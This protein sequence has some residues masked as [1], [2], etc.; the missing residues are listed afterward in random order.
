MG[1]KWGQNHICPL[2]SAAPHQC[3]TQPQGFLWVQMRNRVC[4][5]S[6]SIFHHLH[7]CLVRLLTTKPQSPIV[8]PAYRQLPYWNAV[9]QYTGRG[10]T[11]EFGAPLRLS[12]HPC[13]FP[14]HL[15]LS[16]AQSA[17]VNKSTALF[18][19]HRSP[20][21]APQNMQCNWCLLLFGIL[22]GLKQSRGISS[23]KR[24]QRFLPCPISPQHARH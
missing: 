12:L 14:C 23:V 8:C 10:G 21:F 7:T 24:I 1:L 15:C 4:T 2:R 3:S 18:L 19:H 11:H 16:P 22:F 9:R 13:P 20:Q 17:Q 5:C 6:T